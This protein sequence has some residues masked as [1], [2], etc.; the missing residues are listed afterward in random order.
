MSGNENLKTGQNQVIINVTAV[1][2]ISTKRYYINA[3][4]RNEEEEISYNEE[5]QNN[6]NAANEVIEQMSRDA[7]IENED[8]VTNNENMDEENNEM[9]D[10]VFMICGIILSIIVIGIMIIRIKKVK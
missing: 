3:Y 8:D 10:K 4:K 5:Q 1:N 2:G 9:I 6:I 7:M